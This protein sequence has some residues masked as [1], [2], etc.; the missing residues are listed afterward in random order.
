MD[1]TKTVVVAGASGFIGTY[2]RRRFQE[3]G[4]TVRTIGRKGT[5]SAAAG[6]D[7]DAVMVRVLNGAGLVVNLA[8]RSVSCR[9]N[10]RN[11]ALIMDSRVATTQALGRAIAK[12]P[13]PPSTWL[14]ASTGTIYRD[15]R[16]HPQPETDGELGSGFSV[17]VAKAWEAALAS[18]TTPATRKIPL[19]IAIVLGRGGGALAPFANLARLGLGGHMG[20]GGQKFSWI[21]VEDLYRSIRFLHARTDVTGPV[22]VASPD[23]VSNREMMRL[24]RRAYG[25]RFGLPTPAWLLRAGAV[26]IRTETELVLKSRWVQP[27]KL[28]DA[29]FVYSQPELGRAL[30][31]IAK[32]RE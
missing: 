7:D 17:D 11:K 27:Q 13:E 18:A 25:A 32:G 8:G 23:V 31:Q 5:G 10:R 20:D 3:D 14:N 2:L 6:W 4:W 15:A 24:V 9:Y 16:D 19:R 1:C 26:L 30:L 28:L 21:H 22:N 29:G 12:C